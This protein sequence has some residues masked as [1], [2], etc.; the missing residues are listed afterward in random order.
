MEKNYYEILEVD[1]NASEEIIEKAYKTLA[2]KYHPD[3]QESKTKKAYE[4]KMKIIN[5]AYMVLSD[6]FKKSEYDKQLQNSMVPL[7]E[8]QKVLQENMALRQELEILSYNTNNNISQNQ[9]VN[10]NSIGQNWKNYYNQQV[11]RVA[12]HVYKDEYAQDMKKRGY[13]FRHTDT[14][15]IYIKV[16]VYLM[17]VTLLIVLITKIPF[18]KKWF[19]NFY[20]NNIILKAIVNTFVNTFE[21]LF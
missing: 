1:K 15:K 12:R 21:Q 9:Y 16:A 18:I 7:E 13:V 5:E 3:L 19:E 8:Y 20:E 17:C 6:D 14:V 10:N 4:E 11:N 2:K